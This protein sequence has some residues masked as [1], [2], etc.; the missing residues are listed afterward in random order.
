MKMEALFPKDD[1]YLIFTVHQSQYGVSHVK[2]VSVLDM[3]QLT[4]IPKM[5]M[6]MRGVIPFREGSVP[7]FDLRVAF[8]SKSRLQETAELIETMALRKQDHINWL[9]KLKDEVMGDKPITVQTNPHLCVFGKWYDNFTSDNTNL[10]NY[11]NRID[12][13]HKQI[14]G[15]AIEAEKLLKSGRIG[16]AHEVVHNAEKGTLARL[17][18]LFDGI[19]SVVREYLLEYAIVFDVEGQLFAIAVDD[20][21]LFCKLDHIESPLPSGVVSSENDLVQALG[22]YQEEGHAE[23]K[24]VLLLDIARLLT[25]TDLSGDDAGSNDTVVAV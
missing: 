1:N 16:E 25:Q 9:N 4:V 6:E 11:M 20:I 15:V 17:I 12:E 2:V 21:N 7:L 23:G 13:P 22:L 5:P 8:G 24:D 14:H 10:K 18:G 19:E 3:P